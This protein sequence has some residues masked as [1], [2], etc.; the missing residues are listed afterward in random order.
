LADA[1]TET[2]KHTA[3]GIFDGFFSQRKRE[4]RGS[5]S[6]RCMG[7]IADSR[8]EYSRIGRREFAIREKDCLTRTW[9]KGDSR[10]RYSVKKGFQSEKKVS[11]TPGK[12]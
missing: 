4:C 5:A 10:V 12:K 2:Y 3:E 9:V 11:T 6:T 7:T 8:I 1:F